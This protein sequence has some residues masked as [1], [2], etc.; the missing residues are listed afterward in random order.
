MK[1]YTKERLQVL[2]KAILDVIYEKQQLSMPVHMIKE[3]GPSLFGRDW[4]A[5]VTL[6]WGSMKKICSELET[7]LNK[8]NVLFEEWLGTLQSCH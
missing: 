6:N 2:G 1:T 7:V 4:L 5:K 8:H 3:T